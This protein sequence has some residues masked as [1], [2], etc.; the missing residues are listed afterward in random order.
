LIQNRWGKIS[1]AEASLITNFQEATPYS[2][3]TQEP[4]TEPS[5]GLLLERSEAQQPQATRFWVI[6]GATQAG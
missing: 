4:A 6:R 1:Q 2:E 3:Q 5:W